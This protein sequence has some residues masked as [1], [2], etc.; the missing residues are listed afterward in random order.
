MPPHVAERHR[1]EHRL[2]RVGEEHEPV[3]GERDPV[4][5][6]VVVGEVVG[7]GR[8]APDARECRAAE[9][10]RRAVRVLEAVQELRGQDHGHEVG[11]DEERLEDSGEPEAAEAASGSPLSSDRKSTRLNSSHTVISYAVFC[12]KKKKKNKPMEK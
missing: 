2:H 1:V 7:E 6:V 9:R 3:A 8:E 12:L 4:A 10:D 5:E 11:V